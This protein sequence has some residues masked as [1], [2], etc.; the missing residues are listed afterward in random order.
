MIEDITII[1][2]TRNRP[3]KALSTVR[4]W[5]SNADKTENIEYLLSIDND[6]KSDYSIFE[7]IGDEFDVDAYIWQTPNKSA[8]QAINICAE[9]CTGNILIVVSDDFDCIPHW[10]TLL[11]KELAGK[12]DFLLKTDDGLQKTLVTLPIMDRKY[13]ERFGYIYHPDYLHMHADEEM[14]IIA[15][16]LGRYIK[17]DLLF[18]HLHYT[19]GAM[20]MDDINVKNNATWA[21]GQATLDR[22]SLNNFGVD[23]PL[24]KREDIV[25]R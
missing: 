2:P 16:M 6:D 8:I 14:T 1:H 5:L 22:R 15:L 4:K 13:Y 19:T 3:E 24:V 10:D 7:T 11:L 18:P 9:V 12:E 23:I 25:W 20:Q 21:H 17:S